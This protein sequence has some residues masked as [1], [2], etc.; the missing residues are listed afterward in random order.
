[1]LRVAGYGVPSFGLA[2]GAHVLGG[3]Q[4]PGWLASVLL[5]GVLGVVGAALTGERRHRWPIMTALVLTQSALHE[6]LSA[7][8]RS[9]GSPS[10]EVAC[11]LALATH[12]HGGACS[13]TAL[14]AD[15]GMS[16][17]SVAAQAPMAMPGPAMLV[18]HL[19]AT[20]FTAVLL[21]R[22][23]EWLWRT[24]DA[25]LRIP[26]PV[27]STASPTGASAVAPSERRAGGDARVVDPRGP[28]L[29]EA[30]SFTS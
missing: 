28:P 25:L 23:E 10:P 5:V 16:V 9:T 29:L 8:E 12:P 6:V 30:T 26:G 18:A 15:G 19:A 21:A 20:V 22:G 17:D 11:R 3:G 27:R 1:V 13:S 4:P 2:T 14:L 24:V 7:V